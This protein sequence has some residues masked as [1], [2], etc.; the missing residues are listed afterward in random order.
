M[1]NDFLRDECLSLITRISCLLVYYEF[2]LSERLE[3]K[4]QNS[5]ILFYLGDDF[6]LPTVFFD[7]Y[8]IE[9]QLLIDILEFYEPYWGS[10][11]IIDIWS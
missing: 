11:F 7:L 2:E 6:D 9:C 1:Y 8:S 4:F 5:K 3:V 10:E